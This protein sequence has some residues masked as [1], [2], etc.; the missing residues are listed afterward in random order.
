LDAKLDAAKLKAEI[1]RKAGNN[2]WVL[3]KTIET[4]KGN[5][6]TDTGVP[7]GSTVAYV[8]RLVDAKGKYSTFSNEVPLSF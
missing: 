2:G 5:S 3:V 8:V 1:F 7:K 4:A 6:F